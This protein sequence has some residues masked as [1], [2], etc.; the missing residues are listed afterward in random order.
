MTKE[1]LKKINFHK[2]TLK[3]WDTKDK[4]SRKVRYYRL[5]T[6]GYSEDAGSFGKSDFCVYFFIS[7]Y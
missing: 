7:F 3:F 2:I 1:L 5:K 4:V 6:T